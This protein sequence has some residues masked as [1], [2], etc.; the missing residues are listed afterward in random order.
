MHT[1]AHKLIPPNEWRPI[2][3]RERE[4]ERRRSSGGLRA[5]AQRMACSWTLI[6]S[7]DAQ[8]NAFA[9]KHI[10]C[11]ITINEAN[12]RKGIASD[13]SLDASR[14]HSDR[15]SSQCLQF[16]SVAVISAR[17]FRQFHV[18]YFSMTA[19][20]FACESSASSERSPTIGHSALD[21]CPRSYCALD[22]VSSSS[23]VSGDLCHHSR[24]RSDSDRLT[25][26]L[27][28]LRTLD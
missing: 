14:F 2:R 10:P 18:I 28:N 19:T 20:Q 16:G 15:L 27:A 8:P 1:H 5:G 23:S 7:R 25:Y 3:Q 9:N 12:R 21:T 13:V 17:F 4:R 26:S 11:L 22:A 24:F 6:G